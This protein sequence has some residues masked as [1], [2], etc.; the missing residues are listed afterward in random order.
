MG[1][2][3][4]VSDK[5]KKTQNSYAAVL[6]TGCPPSTRVVEPPLWGATARHRREQKTTKAAMVRTAMD[7]VSVRPAF[8]VSDSPFHTS[9]F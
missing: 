2:D 1:L 4:L 3:S 5:N 8:L 6:P 7:S 9:S